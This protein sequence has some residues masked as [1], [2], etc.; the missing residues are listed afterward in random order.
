METV[1]G[2]RDYSGEES[3]KKQRIREVLSRYFS[4]YGFQ[5]AET[6]L[7]EYEKFVKGE[8]SQDEAVSEIFK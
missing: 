1:K 7:I 4:L 2:F 8:N 6:P 3:S 5:P